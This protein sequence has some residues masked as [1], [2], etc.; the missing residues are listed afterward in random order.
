[1][2]IQTVLG[3]VQIFCLLG[4]FL[5]PNKSVAYPFL[6]IFFGLITVFRSSLPG[7]T[8]LEFVAGIAGIGLFI[9]GMIELMKL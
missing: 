2:K 4:M 5:I 7:A 1:M 6:L 3:M 8:F 9:M